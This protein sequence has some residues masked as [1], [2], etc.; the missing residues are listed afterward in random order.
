MMFRQAIGLHFCVKAGN[1]SNVSLPIVG[2]LI[3]DKSSYNRHLQRSNTIPYDP[4][5]S[6]TSTNGLLKR[7]CE[8]KL[9]G[10]FVLRVRKTITQCK[11]VNYW[12]KSVW[13]LRARD[14]YDYGLWSVF[15]SIGLLKKINRIWCKH[16]QTYIP[17]LNVIYSMPRHCLS[18]IRHQ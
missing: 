9:T 18:M 6:N 8:K 17:R 10:F 15:Q 12:G 16:M 2:A 13:Q 1:G 5:R 4:I 14:V 11:F 7:S 3:F